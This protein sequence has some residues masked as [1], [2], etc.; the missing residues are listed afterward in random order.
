MTGVMMKCI[1]NATYRQLLLCRSDE[2]VKMTVQAEILQSNLNNQQ[3]KNYDFSITFNFFSKHLSCLITGYKHT[4]KRKT[5][6]IGIYLAHCN[7]K[8]QKF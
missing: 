7:F 2:T 1:Q 4:D 8:Y 5:S 6:K 3:E